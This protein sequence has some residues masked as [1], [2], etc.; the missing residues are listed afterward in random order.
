MIPGL[1]IVRGL[2]SL[3]EQFGTLKKTPVNQTIQGEISAFYLIS[4][5]FAYVLSHNPQ[6]ALMEVETCYF[7]FDDKLVT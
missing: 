4:T 3:T 2:V 6:E 1:S 7:C 5:Y